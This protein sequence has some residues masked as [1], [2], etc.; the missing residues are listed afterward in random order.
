MASTDRT[1]HG[2]PGGR[3]DLLDLRDPLAPPGEPSEVD[4]LIVAGGYHLG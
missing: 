3:R 4:E 1:P 2:T